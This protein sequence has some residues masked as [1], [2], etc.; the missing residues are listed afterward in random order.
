MKKLRTRFIEC[1]ATSEALTVGMNF[2][3]GSRNP[4]TNTAFL[5]ANTLSGPNLREFV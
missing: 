4:V 1:A 2:V 3:E 5:V